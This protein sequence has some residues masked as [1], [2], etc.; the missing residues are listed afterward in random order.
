MRISLL[1]PGTGHFYCGS[2]L[3]D[4]M[5]ARALIMRGHDA[6]IHPLYLPLVLEDPEETPDSPVLMG[7][8]NLYLQ[9]GSALFR[10]LPHGLTRWLDAPALLRFVARRGNLTDPGKL[11]RLTLSTL[12]GEDGPMAREV[13]RLARYLEE[14]ERPDV[15]LLS[16]I[17]LCGVARK[18]KARLRCPIVCTLQGEAPFLDEL[19]EPYRGEAWRIIR[20]RARDL[21][22]L[23]PVSRWYAEH[24][25]LRLD[26]PPDRFQVVENGI[27][28]DGLGPADA[29]PPVPTIGYLARL[30]PQKGL[31]T[32]VEAFC[33]LTDL[34]GPENTRLRIAGVLL[35]EDR[36]YLARLEARLAE[37]GLTDRA[38]FLPNLSRADKLRFLRSIS[39]LSVPALYGES[40][41]LYLLEAMACGVPVVQ[42][43]HAAFPEVIEATGGGMLCRPDDPDD[44]GR[45]LARLLRNDEE[46]R[47]LGAAGRL[48]VQRHFT[49]DKMAER[50]E[51]VLNA[52]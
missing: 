36:P 17:L 44:L 47:A 48:G 5:L 52:V 34:G 28:L 32:L 24:M 25:A 40:F 15:I 21:D 45:T 1:T 23:L 43:R 4:H 6:V 29:A 51:A 35:K 42:P 14:A 19:I 11:G 12:L 30:C 16:N 26:L 9:H 38:E 10:R 13:D 33:R 27:A 31:H 41:G 22:R 8:I 49:A 50:V 20:E 2:C 18:L 39:V 37:H 3:R 46:R 7:G